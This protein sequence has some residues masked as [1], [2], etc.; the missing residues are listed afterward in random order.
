MSE[1]VEGT[2]EGLGT[3]APEAPTE[4][5]HDFFKRRLRELGVYDKD[6]DYE[7]SIGEWVEQL[8]ATFRGQGHSGMSAEVTI[9]LFRQ[10]MDE[11]KGPAIPATK[12]K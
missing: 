4:N 7:G 3:E 1:I 9:D 6:A 10:L 12:G 2:A 5:R 8:S 11:W